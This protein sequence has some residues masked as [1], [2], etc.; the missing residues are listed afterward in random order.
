MSAITAL[1]DRGYCVPDVG[2]V[3]SATVPARRAAT[4]KSRKSI[5]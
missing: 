2:M 5:H 3:I 1:L 4:T